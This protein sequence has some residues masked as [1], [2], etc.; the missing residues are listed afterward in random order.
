MEE[1]HTR[2]HYVAL[3]QHVLVGDHA[4]SEAGFARRIKIPMPLASW[5]PFKVW[6]PG[7]AGDADGAQLPSSHKDDMSMT[8]AAM[9][10]FELVDSSSLVLVW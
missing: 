9:V 4:G 6:C 10:R 3:Y 7:I 5:P 1:I 2:E 8:P